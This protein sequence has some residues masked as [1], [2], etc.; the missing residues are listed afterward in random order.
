MVKVKFDYFDDFGEDLLEYLTKYSNK[1]QFSDITENEVKLIIDYDTFEIEENGIYFNII[2]NKIGEPMY[3]NNGPAIY[4]NLVIE[5]NQYTNQDNNLDEIKKFLL[6]ISKLSFQPIDNEIRIYINKN[7]IWTTLSKI[8]KRSVSSLFLPNIDDILDDINIFIN[9]QDEYLERGI[10]YKRNYILYGPPGTGKTSLI[11]I[12]ASIYDFN[13]YIINISDVNDS[14]FIK[15][16]S[17][18]PS[19]S[20]LI[21]E[22]IDCLF[23]DRLTE[24]QIQS[25]ISFSTILNVLDGFLCKNKLIT[26]M[27]TNYKDKLDNALIRPG[28][29]DYIMKF[30]YA[31]KT[32]I[33]DMYNSYFSDN[34][35]EKRNETSIYKDIQLLLNLIEQY[36]YNNDDMNYLYL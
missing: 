13:M 29:I 28:R 25:N 20:I 14:I 34:E 36:G 21:L 5:C 19:N 18:I 23:V 27:T 33:E 16:I 1:Y 7:S 3:S 26:F 9:S 2:Y 11:N 4:T 17:T 22:D 30:D 31:T 32:Q 15:L 35:Y 6:K 8:N 12:I 10:R 24:T